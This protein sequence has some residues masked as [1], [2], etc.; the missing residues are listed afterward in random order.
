MESWGR[1]TNPT[2]NVSR[3]QFCIHQC[4]QL[5]CSSLYNR[6]LRR[7]AGRCF[8]R[9]MSQRP[10]L[11]KSWKAKGT[12]SLNRQ[13]QLLSHLSAFCLHGH[14]S[15]LG[16][17]D[18]SVACNW[19]TMCHDECLLI[20]EVISI[21]RLFHR[22]WLASANPSP[23][24]SPYPWALHHHLIRNISLYLNKRSHGDSQ[25]RLGFSEHRYE[26]FPRKKIPSNLVH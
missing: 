26:A 7:K 19:I 2:G 9:T 3:R 4:M 5:A 25:F 21:S 24:Q 20:C 22:H 16:T 1:S 18:N 14:R 15:C 13:V 11:I 17:G 10:L 6:Q 12:R 8:L 23:I